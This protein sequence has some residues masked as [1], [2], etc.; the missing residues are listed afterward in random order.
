[1]VMSIP[2]GQLSGFTNYE[3]LLCIWNGRDRIYEHKI[4]KW[5][6]RDEVAYHIVWRPIKELLVNSDG[7]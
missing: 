3:C 5:A 7:I 1:M 2:F 4:R 6:A